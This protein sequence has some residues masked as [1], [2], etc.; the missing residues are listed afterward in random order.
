MRVIRLILTLS[1]VL[2]LAGAAAAQ[3]PESQWKGKK[4]AFLGDSITDAHHI[5]TTKN[6]WNF[7]SEMMGLEAWVYGING[8]TW[9]DIPAQAQKLKAEK[10]DSVDAILIFAGTN[11]Y[12]SGVPLG[13]WYLETNG[14]TLVAGPKNATLPR[15]VP[16]LDP[17]TLRGRINL[18]LD[19]LKTAFPR[20]QIIILTPI[21]RGFAHFGDTNVQPDETFANACGLHIDDYVRAIRETADVWAVPVIDLSSICGLY[22][23]KGSYDNCF[24]DVKTDRLHPNAEGHRRLALALKYQL[25]A[26]PADFK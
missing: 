20:Q 13:A 25:L 8:Q 10:G 19:Y 15:R 18:A 5:G 23:L 1:A 16:A 24:H 17:R 2:G 21:H 9:G 26:F 4:V 7:L 14:V 6:Y 12:N 3:V 22:P 11:D